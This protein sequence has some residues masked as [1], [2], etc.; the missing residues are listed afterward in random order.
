M[1][2]RDLLTLCMVE[3]LIHLWNRKF[4]SERA[5][6]LVLI[7]ESTNNQRSG[8]DNFLR[9][10]KS[11]IQTGQRSEFFTFLVSMLAGTPSTAS[12]VAPC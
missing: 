9:K 12:C 2:G 10:I 1:Y 8:Q 11:S 7:P 6:V 4:S 3:C 5:V